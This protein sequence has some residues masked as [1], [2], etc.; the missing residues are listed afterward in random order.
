MTS[1]S[2]APASAVLSFSLS[3][4]FQVLP[5]QFSATILAIDNPFFSPSSSC[6]SVLPS[7]TSSSTLV[8]TSTSYALIEDDNF[9]SFLLDNNSCSLFPPNV[10]SFIIPI[11]NTCTPPSPLAIALAVALPQRQPQ[12]LLRLPAM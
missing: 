8:A 12:K 9:S 10:D 2:L 11:G 4:K 6:M 3:N 7:I 1:F 5:L